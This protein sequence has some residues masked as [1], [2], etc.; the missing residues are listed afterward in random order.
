MP[1][2]TYEIK[3]TFD[4]FANFTTEMIVQSIAEQTK[5]R[6]LLKVRFE[7]AKAGEFFPNSAYWYGQLTIVEKSILRYQAELDRRK[8]KSE[9][10]NE[11]L[12][13]QCN[14]ARNSVVLHHS[15][16]IPSPT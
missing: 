14:A 15:T 5:T 1:A 8:A 7:N 10:L 3:Y 13:T 12:T 11:S 4:P 6:D 2:E 9:T 16:Q